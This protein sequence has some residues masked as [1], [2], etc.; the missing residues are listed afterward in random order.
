MT[1]LFGTT[2]CPDVHNHQKTS[3][4]QHRNSRRAVAN[5]SLSS[6]LGTS[7]EKYPY[8]EGIRNPF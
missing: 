2:N 8:F 1:W 6:E 3:L 4:H 7:T 5:I